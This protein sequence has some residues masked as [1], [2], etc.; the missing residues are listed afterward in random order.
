MNCNVTQT[1]LQIC[2][3]REMDEGVDVDVSARKHKFCVCNV[4]HI[5][6]HG[7]CKKSFNAANF[8]CEIN[9]IIRVSLSWTILRTKEEINSRFKLRLHFFVLCVT[10]SVIQEEMYR[11][12]IF[13][14]LAL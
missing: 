9:S 2:T 4:S 10:Q 8:P 7:Q 11:G 1:Y 5:S 14:S 3:N 12:I 6:G 13:K